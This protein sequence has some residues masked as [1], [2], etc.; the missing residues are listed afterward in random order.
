[1]SLFTP[2]IYVSHRHDP[3]WFN[4]EIRHH[5]KCLRSMRRK[6]KSHPTLHL[7]NKTQL[8]EKLLQSRIEQ[9]KA[10]YESKLIESYHS[11]RHCSSAIHSYIR[12][13]TGQNS[14]PA[15]MTLDNQFAVSDEEKASLFNHYFY[16]VF[17]TSSF[18]LPPI[19]ELTKPSSFIDAVIFNE[20]DALRSLDG[21]K[22]MGCDDISPVVLKHCAIALYQPLYHLFPLSISQYYLP[23]EWRTHLIKPIHKSGDK[24][25]V[26]NYRPISLSCIVSKVLEKVVYD[27]IVE[28][29]IQSTSVYQ[30]GFLRGRSTL[31][32][33]LLFFHKILTSSSQTDVVYLDFKKAFDS[34][35]HNELLLKFG[36]CGSLW[37]WTQAYLTNRL[38]YVAV[39]QS[40]SSALPVLSGV[41]QGSILGHYFLQ[42]LLMISPHPSRPPPFFSLPMMLNVLCMCLL[43]LIVN[44]FKMI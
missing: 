14:L 36:I 7:K 2:K 25:S 32:Q 41:P 5:L 39:G 42:Y 31:Q 38:Q 11:R 29:V 22:A 44:Y 4:S 6:C 20:L 19:S 12:S 17:T 37:L 15:V 23:L 8:S 43:S 13:I 16:S 28:Y 9:A 21:S 27:N 3:K 1:M 10:D 35:A 24:P 33:L 26:R 30:F 34:V 40:L 18:P